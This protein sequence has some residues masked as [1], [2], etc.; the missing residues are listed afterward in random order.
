MVSMLENI[1]S[2]PKTMVGAISTAVRATPTV[3]KIGRCWK[4]N[5]S[6]GLIIG[7]DYSQS[8]ADCSRSKAGYSRN[9]ADHGRKASDYLL[10]GQENG[11]RG[12]EDF[13]VREDHGRRNRGYGLGD[14]HRLHDDMDYGQGR[15]ESSFGHADYILC[16]EVKLCPIGALISEQSFA[17]PKLF[18]WSQPARIVIINS[19]NSPSDPTDQPQLHG[20]YAPKFLHERPNPDKAFTATYRAAR[21]SKRVGAYR[22]CIHAGL[23]RFRFSL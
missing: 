9:D 13:L 10:A 11:P 1:F 17:N 15:T 12:P 20:I 18:F 7:S 6:N 5:F 22:I 23:K 14:S 16:C 21:V 8:D 4:P 19:G 2:P 3:V